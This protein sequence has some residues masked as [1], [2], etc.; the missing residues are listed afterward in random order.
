MRVPA[1][2][3]ALRAFLDLPAPAAAA[4]DLRS[5][6]ALLPAP[7]PRQDGRSGRGPVVVERQGGHT[8]LRASFGSGPRADRNPAA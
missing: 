1:G 7:I 5:A 8:I 3:R 6:A 4:R 2:R